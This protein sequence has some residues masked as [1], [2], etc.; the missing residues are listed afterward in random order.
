MDVAG[1]LT[2]GFGRVNEE[3]HGVVEDLS[4]EGLAFRVDPEANTIAWLVWHLTRIQDDHL[5]DAFDVPQVWVANGWAER[6]ALPFSPWATGYGHSPQEIGAVRMS[7]DLLL[8]YVDAVHERTASLITDLGTADLDRI[9]DESWD[10][11]VS[12]GVRLVSVIS[13]DLQH[14][15]QAAYVRGLFERERA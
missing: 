12:L 14:V 10:P 3:V 1:L 13:D 9:V 8:G 15:G 4:P 6:A 7:A 11:P 2:D 5:A